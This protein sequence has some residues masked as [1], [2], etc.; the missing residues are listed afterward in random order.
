MVPLEPRLR[1]AIISAYFNVL[2]FELTDTTLPGHSFWN[3]PDADPYAWDALNRFS[4]VELIAAMYPRPVCVEWGRDDPVTPP[5]W[6]WQAWKKVAA[7]AADWNLG[8]RIEDDEK[9]S[10][11]CSICHN[12]GY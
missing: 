6:H 3:Q 4:H 7:Y 1:L 2:R 12:I 9:V 8:D 11:S 10:V 5:P